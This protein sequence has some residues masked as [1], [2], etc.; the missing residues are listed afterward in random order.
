[1]SVN[2]SKLQFLESVLKS[3]GILI[4]YEKG[5]FQSGYCLLKERRIAVVNRFFK[6]AARL[7]MLREIATQ[8]FIDPA[9]LSS[10]EQEVMDKLVPQWRE[11]VIFPGALVSNS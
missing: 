2:R 10:E 9:T 8:V 1:M 3:N 11:E 4:R 7:R 6:S 5:N